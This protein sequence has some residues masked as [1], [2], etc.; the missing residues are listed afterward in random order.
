M[1]IILESKGDIHSIVRTNSLAIGGIRKK[2]I[3][4]NKKLV[5]GSGMVKSRE[6]SLI[7]GTLGTKIS[8]RG[9]RKFG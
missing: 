7:K 9:V 3:R 6:G 5:P 8:C 2:K 1:V 4:K